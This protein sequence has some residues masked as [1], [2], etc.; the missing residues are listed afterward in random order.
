MSFT[1]D[2]KANTAKN[3]LYLK[4]AGLMGEAEARKVHDAIL[5]EIR[6]LKPGWA[7]VNDISELK[8]ADE[9]A[10]EHLRR[11]QEASAKAGLSRVVRVVGAQAITNLQWNRTLQQAQG[12][13][14]DVVGSVADADKLLD[15]G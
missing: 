1:Y 8:P 4:L 2:I 14:A 7:V 10:T 6:K 11:A 15:A 5:A 3:R 13:R 12:V 9:K